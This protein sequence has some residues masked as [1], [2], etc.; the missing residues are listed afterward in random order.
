MVEKNRVLVGMELG[1]FRSFRY[2]AIIPSFLPR[3]TCFYFTG[4]MG[5][6]KAL[7]SKKSPIFPANGGIE[8]PRR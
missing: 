4:A 2:G 7:A 3:E 5:E 6:A 1:L 8:I